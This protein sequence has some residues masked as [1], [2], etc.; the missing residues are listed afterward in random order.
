MPNTSRQLMASRH[1]SHTARQISTYRTDEIELASSSGCF[2]TT[3]IQRIA[4]AAQEIQAVQP[5]KEIAL[6]QSCLR[7]CCCSSPTARRESNVTV[8]I[9]GKEQTPY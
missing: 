4:E 2:D 7:F 5:Q 6:D 8:N 1:T 9:G 3:S